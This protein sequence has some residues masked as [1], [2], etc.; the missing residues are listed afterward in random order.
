[1][2]KKYF[3]E[4]LMKY[5]FLISA[6]ISVLSIILICFFIFQGGLPFIKDYGLGNFLLGT[7][8]KPTSSNPQFGIL[9]MIWGTVYITLIACVIGIPIGVLTAAYLAK[10][11]NKK[12]YK[13]L[14]PALNL[15]AG[16][17]SIVY[18]FFALVVIVPL[19][20][21]NLSG[22][23]TSILAAGILLAIMILPTIISLSESAIRA[24]PESY[25][26]GSLAL[27]ATEERSIYKV[28]IPAAKSGIFASVVLGIGRAIGETMAVIL[29]AGGQPRIT[30]N[31]LKG[32]R[33]L[34]TNVVTDMAYAQGQHREA[35]IASGLVLFVF[36][37]IINA[38]LFAVKKRGMANE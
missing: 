15:M 22:K 29:V 24:V 7:K 33:T 5:V 31:P 37:L 25:Y 16:I 4:S 9:P 27:G 11:C 19:I 1:M 35:L 21:D 3:L 32:I 18:G 8:W 34:T 17:P 13:F 2:K 14:K 30:F 23:G 10:S 38:A 12:L 26:N 20:R 28:V 6:L 36:I